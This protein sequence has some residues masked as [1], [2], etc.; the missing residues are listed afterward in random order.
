MDLQPIIENSEQSEMI[1]YFSEPQHSMD[2]LISAKNVEKE[3][4]STFC[5]LELRPSEQ[6]S[7]VQPSYTESRPIYYDRDSIAS[8][9]LKVNRRIEQEGVQVELMDSDGFSSPRSDF[10]SSL[11]SNR[12]LIQ[13]IRL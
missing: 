10:S 5:V 6:N 1:T 4:S 11:P 7:L 12:K 8:L 2:E 9:S 13:K 3:R